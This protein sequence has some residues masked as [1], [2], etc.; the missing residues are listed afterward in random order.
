MCFDRRHHSPKEFIRIS[1]FKTNHIFSWY[2]LPW[3]SKEGQ[4][5]HY[6]AFFWYDKITTKNIF[7]YYIVAMT[8]AI[9]QT[10][11]K[12][13]N[14]SNLA[15]KHQKLKN[16]DFWWSQALLS[17]SQEPNFHFESIFQNDRIV[18]KNIFCYHN[19]H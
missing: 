18:Q 10:K 4:N 12:A 6:I 11:T 16:I 19:V 13:K 3:G 1:N 8:C 14:S 2:R 9:L 15:T 5:F 7:R 17:L